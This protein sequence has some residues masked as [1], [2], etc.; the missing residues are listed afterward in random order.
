MIMLLTFVGSVIVRSGLALADKKT[1]ILWLYLIVAFSAVL[2]APVKPL[3]DSAVMSMLR[4]KSDYGRSRLF[5]QIGFGL[6]SYVVGPLISKDIRL[7][8]IMQLIFAVPTAILMAGFQPTQSEKKK[9]K[10]NIMAAIN[11]MVSDPKVIVFFSMVFLIGVSSGIVENFAYMRIAEVIILDFFVS[12]TIIFIF[13]VV[14][15]FYFFCCLY[16]SILF[17]LLF[18]FYFFMT[19]YLSLFFQHYFFIII[20]S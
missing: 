5:G 3:M 14:F 15:I 6:G 10:L 17:L 16:F 7:I 11:H 19:I 9:E 2:N 13:F 8:F 20:L 1:N 4:D 18:L 12:L